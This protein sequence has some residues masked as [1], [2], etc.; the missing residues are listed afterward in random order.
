[1]E[2]ICDDCRNANIYHLSCPYCF[3][4]WWSSNG[5]PEKCPQCNRNITNTVTGRLTAP[6]QRLGDKDAGK[7]HA[8]MK[9]KPSP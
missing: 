2:G 7:I 4:L 6:A 3:H 5:F 1:M 9:G 8:S